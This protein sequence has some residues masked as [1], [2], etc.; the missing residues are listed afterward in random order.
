MPKRGG[1][2]VSTTPRLPGFADHY[3]RQAFLLASF[4][5]RLL[6]PKSLPQLNL[7]HVKITDAARRAALG[8]LTAECGPAET[9]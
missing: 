6:R 2:F 9:P 7:A 5:P 8:P 1:Q 3:S 4:A